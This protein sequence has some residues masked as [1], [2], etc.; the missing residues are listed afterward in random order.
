MLRFLK[1]KKIKHNGKFVAAGASKRGWASL[2]ITAVDDRITAVM[3]IVFDFINIVEVNF[4]FFLSR[5]FL[6]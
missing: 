4:K 3:P 6:F 5:S 2:M 1:S